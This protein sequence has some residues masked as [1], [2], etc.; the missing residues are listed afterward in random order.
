MAILKSEPTG[1]RGMRV[2]NFHFPTD[3]QIEGL[4]TM[5]PELR[6]T[7]LRKCLSGA[8]DAE[9]DPH[10]ARVIERLEQIEQCLER[11]DADTSQ[12]TGTPIVRHF[13]VAKELPQP[14]I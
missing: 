12:G 9:K 7:V 10:I 14:G 4:L 11:Q 3:A 8:S 5:P 6:K 13:R 2:M 1:F